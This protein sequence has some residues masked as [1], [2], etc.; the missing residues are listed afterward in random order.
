MTRAEAMI[1]RAV[2]L[3][4]KGNERLLGR[5]I[6][7]YGTAVPDAAANDQPIAETELTAADEAILAEL[8][9]DILAEHRDKPDEA[10]ATREREP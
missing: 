10:E 9:N 7:L 8:R 6:D 1:G 3:A 4:M 2:D 5:I